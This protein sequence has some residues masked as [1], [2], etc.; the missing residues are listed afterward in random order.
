MNTGIRNCCLSSYFMSPNEHFQIS[1]ISLSLTYLILFPIS[2][3]HFLP[4]QGR[5]LLSWSAD[6][7]PADVKGLE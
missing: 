7:Q 5:Q 2:W 3:V 6:V 4:L 1:Q